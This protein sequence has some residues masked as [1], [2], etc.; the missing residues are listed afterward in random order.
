MNFKTL[1][2][3]LSSYQAKSL[4]LVKKLPLQNIFEEMTS[5]FLNLEYFQNCSHFHYNSFF[6][7]LH[8]TTRFGNTV[9]T[10]FMSINN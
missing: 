2:E 4:Y 10:Y 6:G 3:M 8:A 9:A 5:N 1:F 7:F